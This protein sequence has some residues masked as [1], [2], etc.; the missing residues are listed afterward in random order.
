MSKAQ[1]DYWSEVT[2]KIYGELDIQ[3]QYIR[4]WNPD[5]IILDGSFDVND[6]ETIARIVKEAK[7][8]EPT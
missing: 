5:D 1:N 4:I 3:G 7:E 8:N 2:T 6:L